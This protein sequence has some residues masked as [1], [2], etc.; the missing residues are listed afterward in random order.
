MPITQL[1]P[2]EAKSAMDEAD[3]SVYLDVRTEI[4]FAQGHP[5]GAINIP[6]ALAGAGGMMPNSDFL[7]VVQKVLTDKDQPIFC[8]C[9]VGGRSQ[10]AADLMTQAGYT[11]LVNVQGGFGGRVENG[12][13][14]VTGW[15]DLGLPV[16]NDVNESNSYASLKTQA[17]G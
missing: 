1:E 14:V 8:G 16:D 3:G 13:L 9:Q 12:A 7:D 4:E 15:R 6:F 17:E 2:Q 10:M 11:N 5:T